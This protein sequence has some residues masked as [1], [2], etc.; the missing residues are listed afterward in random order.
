MP[1]RKIVLENYRC[2]RDRQE[3]ELA[4]V[5]VVLG[6]NNSG[7]SVL[8]R[9]PLVIATGLNTTSSA[10]LDLDSLDPQP[11]DGFADLIFEQSP[12]GR[13]RIGV[14]VD[15]RDGFSLEATIQN[16]DDLRTAFVRDLTL[17]NKNLDLS[18]AWTGASSGS[19]RF[20]YQLSLAGQEPVVR[21]MIFHGLVPMQLKGYLGPGMSIRDFG[22]ISPPEL[23]LG[24]V[25]YLSSFRQRP[26]RQHRLPLGTPGAIGEQGQGV[27]GLLADDQARRNGELLARVN[28]HLQLIVPGWRIEEIESGPLWS[29]VL[30]REGSPVRV[31]LADAGTGLSQVL[32]IIVQC[33]SDGLYGRKA[34]LQIVE[35][36]EMHLHPAAHAELADVYLRT[37]QKTG[38]RFLIETHSE[39]LL[40]RLRRRIAEQKDGITPD[41]VKVYVVEQ[42]DGVSTVRQVGID[43]LGNLDEDWPEGYFSQDYHEVRAL[44]AAQLKRGGYA[45]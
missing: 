13:F 11:V 42:I 36:P 17:R 43:R 25:R 35:E 26:E 45:S 14:E 4:P 22:T 21:P 32:P 44:A 37:A 23:T 33:A 34:A 19:D 3:I 1:L 31:N 28:E 9:A 40:L 12:H 20:D 6:K 2:F 16:L 38:T 5:T 27:A 29:T 41:M 18:L 8:T 10:P 7:K 15:G 30:T 24:Q 39:T